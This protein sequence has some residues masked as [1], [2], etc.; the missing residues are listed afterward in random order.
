M[1]KVVKGVPVRGK[2]C[3]WLGNCRGQP[4]CFSCIRPTV[5]FFVYPAPQ[6]LGIFL[7]TKRVTFIT[8]RWR[9]RREV[10]STSQVW[11]LWKGEGSKLTH[12]SIRS[13][14]YP[15]IHSPLLFVFIGGILVRPKPAF[16]WIWNETWRVSVEMPFKIKPRSLSGGSSSSGNDDGNNNSN[17]IN[18][19]LK[20]VA[21]HICW[22][23]REA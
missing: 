8:T 21:L 3:E 13:H 7:K 9:K 20:T 12:Q 16:W 19:C 23:R 22:W 5:L 10:K 6:S 4:F 2:W 18:K 14:K 15:Q 17:N 11:T 1:V